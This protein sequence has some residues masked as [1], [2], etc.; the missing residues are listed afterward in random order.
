MYSVDLMNLS[1]EISIGKKPSFEVIGDS[2]EDA[3]WD[4]IKSENVM[5]PIPEGFEA[6]MAKVYAFGPTL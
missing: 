6:Y 3:E 4:E 2:N 5:L 1:E